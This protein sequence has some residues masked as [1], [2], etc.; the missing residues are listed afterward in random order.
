MGE[1]QGKKRG[2]FSLKH[3]P[4]LAHDPIFNIS[5]ASQNQSFI[6]ANRAK[7]MLAFFVVACAKAR[8]EVV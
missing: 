7:L 6:C 5:H 1:E 2:G 8:F 4:E 3:E